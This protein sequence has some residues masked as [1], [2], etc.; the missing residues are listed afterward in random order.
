MNKKNKLRVIIRGPILTRSGYGEQA[1][2]AY[3]A[4]KTR[5]D[6][7]DVYVLPTNWG[8]CGWTV[9]DDEERK[10]LDEN[11]QTTP[12]YIQQCQQAQKH[13][14]DVSVQ[15]TIPNEWEA[16]APV[17]IGYTA[18]TETDKVSA[19]WLQAANAVNKIIAVSEHTKSGF[20]TTEYVGTDET[21]QQAVLTCQTPVDVVNFPAKA[22]EPEP[23]EIETSTS[24]NFLTVAQW[25][26]RKNLTNLIYG[27]AK[28]FHDNAEVGL[29]VKANIAKNCH[30]DKL[31]TEFNIKQVLE[32]VRSDLDVE[33]LKCKIYLLHGNMTDQEMV[34][35]Y[36]EP[37]V[38]AMIN[39][40]HGEGFGLPIFEAATVGLP[41]IAPEWS[42]QCDY[43]YADV[44]QR[45]NSKRS[46]RTKRRFLATK[47][48]TTIGPIQDEAVWEDVLIKE[49]KWCYPQETSYR[50]ALQKVYK[51]HS[52]MMGDAKKL[53]KNINEN[54]S[55]E[56][57]NKKFVDSVL[58]TVGTTAGAQPAME[59]S[60][61][62]SVVTL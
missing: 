12:L 5:P 47:V 22:I 35:L 17:N 13:P 16:L 56:N 54:M 15:V 53:A 60:Q 18:G 39:L 46:A 19:K 4:L 20:M 58:E 29:I 33:S 24:F 28:E 40:A 6:L 11:I 26:P 10:A 48:E 59:S 37:T 49:S 43:L 38:K 51:Q 42:G 27:F 36:T 3:R 31:S 57:Q 52:R 32:K 45:A 21:G 34:G 62:S 2:F 14:F 23:I 50:T 7:F 25:G 44:K 8:R 41:I 1:R 61:F 9:D 55:E 30:I